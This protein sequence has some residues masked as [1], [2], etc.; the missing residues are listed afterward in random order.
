MTVLQHVF[1]VDEVA[2]VHVLREIVGVVEVD[3]AGLMRVDN[4][5]RQQHTSRQILGDFACHIVALDGVDGRVLVGVFL[6]DLFVVR[7]DQGQDLLV[8][9]VALA[10]ERAGVAVGDVL[11]GDLISSVRHDLVL[12][13]ILNFLHAQGAVHPETGIF[14]ALGDAADLHRREPLVLLDDVVRLGDGGDDLH[15]VKNGL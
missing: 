2:V 15:N 3:D 10:H 11:L 1:E 7:L 6:L 8:G 5:F 13:Q 9:R 14:H 4:L 12:D